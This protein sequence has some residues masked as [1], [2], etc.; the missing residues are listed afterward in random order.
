MTIRIVLPMA[1]RQYAAGHSSFDVAGDTIRT[2][3]AN[4]TEQQADLHSHL[5]DDDGN[6]HRYLNLFVN[7]QSVLDAG[8]SLTDGD[9]LLI[10]SAIAGG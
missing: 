6:P 10:V 9:E 3:L 5:L 8:H 2:A 4:L 1:L 7:E